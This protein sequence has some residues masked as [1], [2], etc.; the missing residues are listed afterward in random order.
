MNF[1]SQLP[2]P[3]QVVCLYQWLPHFLTTYSCIVDQVILVH[4]HPTVSHFCRYVQMDNAESASVDVESWTLVNYLEE[5][6]FPAL[7]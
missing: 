3:G 1:C 4:S 7:L 2:K 5:G 6:G